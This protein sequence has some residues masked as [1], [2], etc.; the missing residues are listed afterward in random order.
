MDFIES[1]HLT[2]IDLKLLNLPLDTKIICLN[3]FATVKPTPKFQFNDDT[4]LLYHNRYNLKKRIPN[5]PISSMNLDYKFFLKNKSTI[6]LKCCYWSI[7]RDCN[8]DDTEFII[9]ISANKKEA[10]QWTFNLKHIIEYRKL[11][12]SKLEL[13]M[14]NLL[15]ININ[16]TLYHISLNDLPPFSFN[17]NER[18]FKF[19][20]NLNISRIRVFKLPC[21]IQ[22]I[23]RKI[24]LIQQLKDLKQYNQN[25]C[26]KI[27][28]LCSKNVNLKLYKK[29]L[30]QSKATVYKY[31][32][33]FTNQR[34]NH[35]MTKYFDHIKEIRS[36]N[37][38]RSEA[39][40]N[41]RIELLE[42]IKCLKIKRS[43][44]IDEVHKCQKIKVL[45]IQYRKK[46]L[47]YYPDIFPI[48]K[49]IGNYMS[50]CRLRLETNN[51]E[52]KSLNP[53]ERRSAILLIAQCIM[54]M[55]NLLDHPL[56]Y[57]LKFNDKS[58]LIFNYLLSQ[59]GIDIVT[60]HEIDKIVHYLGENINIIQ[61]YVGVDNLINKTKSQP[62]C[63][64]NL[65]RLMNIK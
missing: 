3:M 45:I 59:S 50:I 33:Q 47:L 51:I 9:K 28:K 46:Q 15:F 56:R 52:E 19:I 2:N 21:T 38:I 53:R 44:Y 22:N 43:Q 32:K 40:Q 5:L 23:D 13:S 27:N 35:L 55:S 57:P 65:E 37:Q 18:K 64:I 12:E 60:S 6:V 42:N 14:K 20:K 63:L 62:L 41:S 58:I 7:L 4:N 61:N 8:I 10:I 24:K 30:S 17:Q 39:L 48:K 54:S 26:T 49:R 1:L 11:E 36:E 25:L 16:Y 29:T 31:C 34:L